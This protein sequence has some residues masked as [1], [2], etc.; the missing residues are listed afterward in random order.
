MMLTILKLLKS[1][2]IILGCITAALTVYFYGHH[3]GYA[4][5]DLEMQSEISA[6][7]EEARERESAVRAELDQTTIQLKEANDA[8]T[9]K[10]TALD[11]AISSGR[12][13][14]KSASCVQA[15]GNPSP[16][17]SDRDQGQTESDRETLRLIAQIAADG[18]RAIV[19]LNA[20]IDAYNQVREMANG[21][22]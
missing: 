12:V 2:W 6:K 22:R 14:F 19:Q 18:D 3:V 15:N 7:N 5:R 1:P 17:A 20:C 21:H 16:A 8:I 10:Q 9:Q 4:L 13:R 11:R